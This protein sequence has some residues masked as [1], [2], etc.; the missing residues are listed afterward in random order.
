MTVL[1]VA[2]VTHVL[3][4]NAPGWLQSLQY[5]VWSSTLAARI[6]WDHSS[7]P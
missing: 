7:A 3:T 6:T 2:Y 4:S 5:L 1:A